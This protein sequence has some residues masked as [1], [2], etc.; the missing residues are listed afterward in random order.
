MSASTSA[1][2][3]SGAS[4]AMSISARAA[5]S[6]AVTSP[7][8]SP[9][10]TSGSVVVVTVGTI[11]VEVGEGTL[12]GG[13]VVLGFGM[14]LVVVDDVVDGVVVGAGP[15]VVAGSA[16]DELATVVVTEGFGSDEVVGEAIEVEVTPVVVVVAVV[17]GV[18]R[19]VEGGTLV[20][21]TVDT[22]P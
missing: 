17:A 16:T 21:A 14:V 8:T 10:V 6:S 7:S 19:V 9:A 15:D 3:T 13:S 12:D 20:T 22:A 5:T 11:S 2:T 1:A 18:V 4:A